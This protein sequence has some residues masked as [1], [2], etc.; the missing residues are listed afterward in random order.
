MSRRGL[1]L[2]MWSVVALGMTVNAGCINYRPAPAPVAA[3]LAGDAPERVWRLQAGRGISAPVVTEGARAYAGGVDRKVYAIDLDSGRVAWDRRLSGAVLGGVL[4]HDSVLFV[5]TARPEGRVFALDKATGRQRWRA[6][7]GEVGAPLGW[8]G[9][10][11]L[12][13]TRRGDLVALDPA[14]GRPRWRRRLGSIRS[15]PVAVDSG[16]VVV[17]SVDSLFRVATADGRVTHRRALPGSTLRAWVPVG[18]TLVAA[19][20][21]STVVA[22]RRDDLSTV[23]EAH[24]DAP[25][26]GAPA[27]RGDTMYVVSRIGTLYRVPPG[28]PGG[29]SVV[30]R[31]KW[32]VTSGVALVDGRL[33][34]GGADGVLR[35]LD[36]DGREVWR[37][38]LWRPIDVDPLPL[39]DGFLA[40]GGNGD[41]HRYR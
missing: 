28:A 20:T 13:A 12:A 26:F 27:I 16:A 1:Q 11:V 6:S 10:V 32:P 24:A 40:V 17:A 4:T 31:L 34:I 39:A 2:G 41:F 18:E 33:V 30:A 29:M 14:R 9:G 7:V 19:T 8:A 23:W 25:L 37:L 5:A 35:A 38:A 3:E 15:A 22:V 21:D 36:A